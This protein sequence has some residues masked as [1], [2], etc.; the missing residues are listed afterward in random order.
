MG[1]EVAQLPSLVKISATVAAPST[2]F[3]Y[4][5]NR[6]SAPDL[7]RIPLNIGTSHLLDLKTHSAWGI[8]DIVE[9]GVAVAAD[10]FNTTLIRRIDL[11]SNLGWQ[12]I[13]ALLTNWTAPVTPTQ[14]T[15]NDLQQPIVRALGLS[16]LL[17]FSAAILL[18]LLLVAIATQQRQ[19]S[20]LAQQP[21]LIG[22]FALWIASD[23]TWLMQTRAWPRLS[24]TENKSWAAVSGAHLVEPARLAKSRLQTDKP[25]MI[26]PATADAE[27]EAQKLPFMLLPLK[28]AFV[29]PGDTRLA[30]DWPGNIVVIGKY[31]SDVDKVAL[32]LQMVRTGEVINAHPTLAIVR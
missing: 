10:G 9:Y 8:D 6:Q 11:M 21:I 30:Q 16:I 13:P 5:M 32:G 26:I 18:S 7:N 2:T 23:I 27:F 14:S 31:A 15:L 25:V 1:I 24:A 29:G 12:D 4:W 22:L 28:S 20:V 3:F 17:N 19:F